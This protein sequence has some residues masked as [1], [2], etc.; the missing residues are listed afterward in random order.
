MWQSF[1]PKNQLE[2][3]LGHIKLTARLWGAKDKPLL[4]ALH[5]W[6]DNANSFEP[7]AAYLS[8]YQ[9]LAIDWPGHGFS[10]HRPGQYPLHW[11]DYLYD[12]DALLTVLPQQPYAIVGHSLGGIVAAA[13]TAAFPEKVPK[14]ILIEAL[15]PLFEPPEQAKGRLRKS[16]MQHGKWLTQQRTPSLCGQTDDQ[17]ITIAT[18]KTYDNIDTAVKARTQLTGLAEPWCRLLIERNMRHVA[19]GVCW[20]SDPRLRLDSP[21]RLTFAQV[22]ALMQ[23]IDVETLLICGKQGF[24]QLQAALPQAHSWF[25]CLSAQIIDGDH[26]LHMGNAQQTALLIQDFLD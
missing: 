21:Q 10:Q 5:G 13:Y 16:V 18:V 19:N 26:H 11:V 2:F 15:S 20:R 14:L 9:I 12:L 7:L 6:L 25:S 1:A 23:N 22:D 3:E 4:L 17:G 24:A 8:Q